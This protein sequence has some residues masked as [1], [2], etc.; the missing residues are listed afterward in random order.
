MIRSLYIRVVL[1]FLVSVIAG[2]VISFFVSTMIFEDQLNENAQINIRNFGQD[3]VQI[4]KTLPLSEAE[5]YVSGMKLLNSYHIRIYDATGQFQSYGKLNGHKSATVTKE[6]LKKV[7]DGG[8]V[9]D[10]PNGIATVLLGLPVK[11]EMGAK[12]MFFETLTPPSSL[13]VVQ[14]ASIFATCSLI[15]GSIII[16]IASIFLVRPI[17]KLT[18]ATKRIAAGDFNVKLNIK[19]TG[20][21]GT[22]ARSFEEMI[23]DLQQLEQMRREF[24]TNVSHEVQSPLTSI[25]GYAQALKQVNLSEQERSRYLEI[26]IAEA[27]RMSKMSDNLLKLSMLE[28]QSQQP[29]LSTLSLD[30]QIRR[31]IVTLQPQWSA[32]NIHFELDLQA[33]KVLA[34][35]DQLNQVWTNILSNGIKFSKDG[36]VIHVSTKQDIKNVTIRISDTGIGI[37]LED[38]KRIFERFF[39]SDRSHSR[40]YDGSGMGLAIVKQIVSLHQG[41]IRVESEPGQGTTFIVTLPITPPTE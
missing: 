25:S 11:T 2:T 34:D 4:Y 7:L 21:L 24:V 26:I 37:P 19:Q 35:H 9:Q 22:L 17:K 36:G 10:N 5:S 3:I 31:V 18:K 15:A 12:A 14:W 41:D 28:S 6:Q 33:V 27:K 40:K 1:T 13:F 16:L 29:R 39:K 8:V 23:H 30:E 32:R 38:Q 20:E